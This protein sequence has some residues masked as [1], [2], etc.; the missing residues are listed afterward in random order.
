MK[1]RRILGGPCPF[2]RHVRRGLAKAVLDLNGD[3]LTPHKYEALDSPKRVGFLQYLVSE[4]SDAILFDF[5]ELLLIAIQGQY[6]AISYCWGTQ[7]PDRYL[8]M[9]DGSHVPITENVEATFETLNCQLWRRVDLDRSTR[10]MMTRSLHR[11]K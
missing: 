3:N 6:I 1:I 5:V 8:P 9:T 2:K 10:R 11:S 7:Q 4:D